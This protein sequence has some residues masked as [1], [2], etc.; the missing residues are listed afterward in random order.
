MWEMEA[1]V[2]SSKVGPPILTPKGGGEDELRGQSTYAKPDAYE[3]SVNSSRE[4][5]TA[6]I[7]GTLCNFPV[8]SVVVPLPHHLFPHGK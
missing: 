8:C 1:G 2:P 3:S 6:E 4:S 5:N 7:S